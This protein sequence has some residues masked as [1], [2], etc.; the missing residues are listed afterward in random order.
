METLNK[1]RQIRHNQA[2]ILGGI[3]VIF[4]GV[5][6]LLNR[7]GMDIP[8]WVTSWKSILIAIGIVT[9]YK[10]DFKHFFG[11]ILI[12]LGGLFMINEFRPDTISGNLFWPILIIVIGV[13]MILKATRFFGLQKKNQSP[14][15]VAFD[16]DVEVS[17]T[18]YI[19]STAVFGG[20]NKN[21]VTKNFEGASLT[22][23]FGG[24]EIN[25]TQADIQKPVTIDST[26]AFGGVTLIVPS[27]WEVRSELTTVFG[28]L[29][30]KRPVMS[31][32]PKD[33]NKVIILKGSCF[34]GGVEIQSYI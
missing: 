33:P 19:E 22:T 26:S 16:D 15:L 32:K 3:F 14:T 23:Y 7:T 6:Y 9:L 4:F 30:D 2:K 18:D 28:G 13:T 12:G 27:T 31:D 17:S 8:H 20:V 10:H 1:N 5:M 11:Y 24:T 29:E 25:L 34:F 21:I